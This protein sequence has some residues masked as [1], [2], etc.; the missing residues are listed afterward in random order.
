MK[1]TMLGNTGLEVSRI[2]LGAMPFGMIN[3]A[4]GWDPYTD[5]GRKI[6]FHT[7]NVALDTGI[8]YID[9]APSYGDG[10]AET[11]IG[12]VMKIRR[13]EAVLASKFGWE[14]FYHPAGSMNKEAVIDS[15]EGSL[16]RL[17]TDHLDLIQIHGGVYDATDFEHIMNGGV[18]EAMKELKASGKVGHIGLT[19]EDPW[20]ALDLIK[21][22]EF[23]VVQLA[24]NIIYQSAALH[25]LEETSAGGIGVQTMR[26][27]T[28]GIFQRE[29][30]FIAPEWQN[31]RDINEVLLRFQLSDSR[32]HVA[33]VGM[34]W[35]SEV[36]KNNAVVD[37]WEPPFDFAGIARSTGGG[38]KIEDAEALAK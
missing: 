21:T 9:V 16:S 5:G 37:A 26:S 15:V 25:V 32:V 2:G 18:L 14:G 1:K 17:Q 31:A 36:E 28:G 33:N 12:E 27:L 13:D 10:Y 23:E 20:T 38:Y 11:I 19:V 6:A 22:G 3:S 29:L 7:I 35:A 34:R 8:N 24:Y 4:N 30:S